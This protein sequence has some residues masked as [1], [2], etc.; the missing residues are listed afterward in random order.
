M[1]RLIHKFNPE[2]PT[3]QGCSDKPIPGITIDRIYCKYLT[4]DSLKRGKKPA[5]YTIPS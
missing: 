1:V 4:N 2:A 5:I 3:D